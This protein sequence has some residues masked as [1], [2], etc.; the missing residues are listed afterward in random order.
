MK[1]RE[2]WKGCDEFDVVSLEY[3]IRLV[4]VADVVL[5]PLLLLVVVFLLAFLVL[6]LPLLQLPRRRCPTRSQSAA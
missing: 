1:I 4:V 6:L 5:R 3:R 2:V